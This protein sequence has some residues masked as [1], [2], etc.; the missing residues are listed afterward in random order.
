MMV[1]DGVVARWCV[2]PI[3][4]KYSLPKAQVLR[5]THLERRAAGVVLRVNK[6]TQVVSEVRLGLRRLWV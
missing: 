4:W 2:V 5:F 3:S 6:G 1:D